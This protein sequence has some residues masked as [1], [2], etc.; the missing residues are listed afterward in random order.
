MCQ[1]SHGVQSY[2]VKR[3]LDTSS[4][5]RAKKITKDFYMTILYFNQTQPQRKSLFFFDDKLPKT[6]ERQ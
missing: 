2:K 6:N 1:I 4:K 3:I 5:Y